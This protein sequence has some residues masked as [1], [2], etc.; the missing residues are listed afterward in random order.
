LTACQQLAAAGHA[1][2]RTFDGFETIDGIPM[3]F[4]QA[5]LTEDEPN[6]ETLPPDCRVMGNDVHALADTFIAPES[7]QAT[8]A[9]PLV[10]ERRTWWDVASSYIA[11]IIRSGQYG[12]A[13]QLYRALEEKAGVDSPF[14]KGTGD[15]RGSLFVREIAQPLALKTVQNRFKDLRALANK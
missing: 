1:S 15:N 2:W 6:F 5:M 9:P 11:E 8:T 4:I 13:K 10:A 12:T 14:D 7:A 3:R